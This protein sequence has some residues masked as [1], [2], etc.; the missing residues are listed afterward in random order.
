M[1]V[2]RDAA[3]PIP[4]PWD[5]DQDPSGEDETDLQE[6]AAQVSEAVLAATDWTTE[7]LLNQLRRGNIELNPRFQRRDAWKTANRKSRFIE[8]ILLGLPIPQIVLAERPDRRGSYI[9]IDGKQRL[10]TLRQFSAEADGDEFERLVLDGLEVRTDLNGLTL[11]QLREDVSRSGDLN[12]FENHTIRTVVV[13]NWPD[14]DFLYLVFLRLNTGSLPLSPQELRQALHPGPFID[15]AE[16]FSRDSEV[17]HRALGVEQPDFR[18]RDVELLVR[19]FGFASFLELYGGNLKPFLDVTCKTLNDQWAERGDWIRESAAACERAIS[20]TEAV[21]GRH[22]F[23]RWTGDRWERPF[24]RAVFDAMA[25]Y[26]RDPNVAVRAE[27]SRDS[28]IDAFRRLSMNDPEF[29]R[30]LQTTTKTV[31]ATYK[32]LAAWGASLSQALGHPLP[33]PDL[34]DNRIHYRPA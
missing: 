34:V 15:F 10:L 17:I 5:F 33:V 23:R 21:F 24:N 32:R 4:L 14:E 31:P 29:A 25:F 20:A 13:R 7:T 12:A 8:S 3:E 26:F 9:V 22:A 1:A 18:M 28:V 30:A 11:A 16:E 2:T 27:Q 6:S 19:F